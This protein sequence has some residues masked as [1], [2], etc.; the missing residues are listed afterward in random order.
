M[1]SSWI[2]ALALAT[3]AGCGV[4]G[5]SKQETL[6]F[7]Y[8]TSS[9]D[10]EASK[11]RISLLQ[12][13]LEK[14]LKMKVD[15][16]VG[17]S[18][19]STIEAMRA[20]RVDAATMGPMSYLL[21]AQKANAE[22]IAIPGTKSGGPGTYQSAIVVR[23]DSPVQTIDE[24]LDHAEKYTFSFVDPSSTSGHLIPRAYLEGRDFNPEKRFRKVHFANDHLTTAYTIIG[25]KVDAGAM[26]PS[27]IQILE[28]KGKIKRGE[29]KVL[30]ESNKIPMSP[31][32][33]RKDLAPELKDRIRAAFIAI[34][35]VDPVLAK[36]MQIT[37]QYTDFCYYP[38]NDGMYDDLRK[39]ARSQTKMR[40][41][42]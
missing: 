16:V 32:S 6:K 26:M 10:M 8:N 12:A 19:S 24:L 38:A 36:E 28:S 13:Y 29:L 27:L 34:A 9:D 3:L 39:I 4:G 1:R 22:A 14:A 35:D 41:I 37:T 17:T 33:V 11:K 2:A 21:A 42:D 18:Y 5:G 23:G 40:L 7:A 25:K 31:L 30:W 15:M 20:K